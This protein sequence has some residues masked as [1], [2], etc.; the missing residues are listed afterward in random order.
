MTWPSP[1]AETDENVRVVRCGGGIGGGIGGA[2]G[3]AIG[4]G[5]GGGG[6]RGRGG[7]KKGRAGGSRIFWFN[8]PS[9]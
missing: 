3:G 1:P 5:G 2:I 4:G 7:C 9:F 8:I 6:K